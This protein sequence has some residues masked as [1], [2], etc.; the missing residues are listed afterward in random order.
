M[1]V[2]I[3]CS[4]LPR[5]QLGCHLTTIEGRVVLIDFCLA[6]TITETSLH[7]SLPHCRK[8]PLASRARARESSEILSYTQYSNVLDEGV[9]CLL[10][11]ELFFNL[12]VLD[13]TSQLRSY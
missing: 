6:L 1:M 4:A 2:V 8:F 12:C 7:E 5:M 13:Y 10:V 9:V 3:M 11:S